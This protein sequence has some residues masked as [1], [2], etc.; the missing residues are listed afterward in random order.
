MN[1]EMDYIEYPTEIR[2][3]P[4][5]HSLKEDA[6]RGIP[7]SEGLTSAAQKFYLKARLLY[8]AKLPSDQGRREML[9][10][11]RAYE[12]DKQS[13]KLVMECAIFWANVEA[14]AS[15]YAKNPSIETADAFYAK[16]YNLP[17]N[18]RNDRC[19]EASEC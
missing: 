2:I 16:V 15:E 10:L 12:H 14:V 13:E 17:L 4:T 6:Y 7:L 1:D 18:W 8:E 5:S 11:E 3:A 9:E 19:L